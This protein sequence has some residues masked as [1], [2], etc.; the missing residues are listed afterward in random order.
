MIGVVAAQQL[1]VLRRQ[2]TVL[3]VVS[4]LVGVTVLAG[5]IGW[6]SAATISRVYD[7]SVLLLA[8]QGRPAPTN[9]LG[10]KPPL[11]LLSNMTI[12]VPMV[13]A[14]MNR[15]SDWDWSM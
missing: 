4:V 12:Y 13:G 10:L 6:S 5:V 15:F 8:A 7:Q 9:P 14:L 1:T 3:A 11:S 2:R